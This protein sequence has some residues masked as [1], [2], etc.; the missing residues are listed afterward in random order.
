MPPK[1]RAESQTEVYLFALNCLPTVRLGL[2]AIGLAFALVGGGMVVSFFAFSS[3]GP[4]GYVARSITASAIAPNQTQAW[5]LDTVGTSQGTLTFSWVSDFRAN[6]SLWKATSCGQPSGVC[7]VGPALVR[8]PSDLS[9]TWKSSGS[10]SSTYLVSVSDATLD[11]V[12]FNATLAESYS[13]QAFGLPATDLVFLTIG[14][15]LLLGTG[16]I[17]VFLGLF[18]PGGVYRA[19]SLEDDFDPDYPEPSGEFDELDDEENAE[20][21]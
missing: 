2:V 1:R 6:V 17:G 16:A 20:P 10:I 4:P 19:P 7:P 9:G 11:A 13:D 12:S 14:S 21:P 18:L 3:G 8:W 15:I 5:S